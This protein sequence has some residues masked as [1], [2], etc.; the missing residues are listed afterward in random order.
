MK[1]GGRAAGRTICVRGGD[2]R[3]A[4]VRSYPIGRVR[5]RCPEGGA[6][7]PRPSRN[8]QGTVFP[9]CCA[10]ENINDFKYLLRPKGS[11]VSRGQYIAGANEGQG[12]AQNLGAGRWLS[13]T[14]LAK[15][16]AR[17]P[18]WRRS[19]KL[20][21]EGVGVNV[22]LPQK[23]KTGENPPG[24]AAG[25]AIFVAGTGGQ[26]LAHRPVAGRVSLAS[27]FVVWHHSSMFQHGRMYCV[28]A[29]RRVALCTCY[30]CI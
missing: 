27:A 2:S 8:N 11:E 1:S 22:Y 3:R 19:P 7:S 28:P 13:S 14:E 23:R 30:T 5:A 18:A 10:R 17:R 20:L 12:G 21:R 26:D 4:P 16:L 24:S 6:S 9:G 29:C 15:C 25:R